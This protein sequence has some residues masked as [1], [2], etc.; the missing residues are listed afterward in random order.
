MFPAPAISNFS[1][2]PNHLLNIFLLKTVVH[3]GT[4]VDAPF[5]FYAD[6]PGIDEIPLDR[7][8]GSGVVVSV[9]LAEFGMINAEDLV[10]ASPAIEEG[11]I[12]AVHTGW[13]SR[14][15]SVSWNRRPSFSPNAAEWLVDM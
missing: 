14:W 3:V 1:E 4:Y 10:N 6:G 12:V 2:M 13:E 9:D 7:L 5:H 11:D 8:I 15:K